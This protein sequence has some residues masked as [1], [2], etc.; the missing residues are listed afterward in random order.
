MN[1]LEII[2]G[3]VFT[4]IIGLLPAYLIRYKVF[5]KPLKKMW[6]IALAFVFWVVHLI[7]ITFIQESQGI[8]DSQHTSLSFVAIISFYIM[9]KKNKEKENDNQTS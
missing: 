7:L 2:I 4:W 3:I 8:N 9:I 6:A 5:K 1:I